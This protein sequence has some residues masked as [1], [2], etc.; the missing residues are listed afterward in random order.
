MKLLLKRI[1]SKFDS[2]GIRGAS[3]LRSLVFRTALISLV[4]GVTVSGCG[5]KGPLDAPNAAVPANTSTDPQPASVPI[6]KKNNPVG[7][8]LKPKNKPFFLDFL[9]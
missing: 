2:S 1:S 3:S 7:D 6:P 4:I 5:R 8:N 9:L